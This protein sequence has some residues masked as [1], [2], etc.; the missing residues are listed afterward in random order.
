MRKP[1]IELIP[2]PEGS[3]DCWGV[4]FASCTIP[5]RC[6]HRFTCSKRLMQDQAK[7]QKAHKYHAKPVDIDDEHFDS[8]LEYNC[9]M[10]YRRKERR[11]LIRDIVRQPHF[12]L[13]VNGKKIGRGYTGDL[14][15]Y[16]MDGQYHVVDA[17][18]K[19]TRDWPKVR[20]LMKACHDIDVELWPKRKPRRRKK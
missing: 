4:G 13:I 17:K 10:A 16:D 2:R 18:G 6:P 12:D 5:D 7:S 20:D 9:V 3:P 11:G 8:T 19:I 14:A 15:Y 1:E